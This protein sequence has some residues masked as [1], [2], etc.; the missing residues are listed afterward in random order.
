MNPISKTIF[1]DIGMYFLLTGSMP[2]KYLDIMSQIQESCYLVQDKSFCQR[3][4]CINNKC[5]FHNISFLINRQ[6]TF[7]LRNGI[8]YLMSSVSLYFFLS[9]ILIVA[10]R[11]ISSPANIE[12][13]SSIEGRNMVSIG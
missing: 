3:R 6:L 1:F 5:D 2:C 7:Q 11:I 4:K 8:R 9:L 13:S 12:I 10:L